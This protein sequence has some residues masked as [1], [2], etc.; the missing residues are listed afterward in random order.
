MTRR[1][2]LVP[3][4][5]VIGALAVLISLGVW[6]LQRATWKEQLLA[7]YIAAE[8]LP[9]IV[10]PTAPVKGELPLFRHA[11]GVCVRPVGKRAIAGENRDGEPGYVQIVDCATGA[12]GP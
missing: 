1:L 4:I 5:V 11:T 6:Q 9:P 12:E 3:T 2:P 7:R 8:K 10:W